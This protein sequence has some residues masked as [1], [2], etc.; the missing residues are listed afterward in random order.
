MYL[1]CFFQP[2]STRDDVELYNSV[3]TKVWWFLFD[4]FFLGYVEDPETG[5][6]FT[7]PQGLQWSFYFEVCSILGAHV[8]NPKDYIL[9]YLIHM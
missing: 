8:D 9:P 7:M 4:L 6:S 5:I 1:L 3:M 2:E